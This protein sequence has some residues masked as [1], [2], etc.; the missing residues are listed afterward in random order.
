MDGNYS[1]EVLL[2]VN[3]FNCHLKDGDHLDPSTMVLFEGPCLKIY[4]GMSRIEILFPLCHKSF[5]YL[6]FRV[7][8]C[9]RWGLDSAGSGTK[10]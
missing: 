5:N 8:F 6:P 1:I 2:I 4:I 9:K 10:I 3:F 7:K